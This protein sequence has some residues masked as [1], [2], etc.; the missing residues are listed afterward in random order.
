[1]QSIQ[2]KPLFLINCNTICGEG[3]AYLGL[4]FF[5]TQ[6]FP[7][8]FRGLSV[9]CVCHRNSTYSQTLSDVLNWWT[10]GK[11][12]SVH[13]FLPA[14]YHFTQQTQ[15]NVLN[16]SQIFPLFNQ[17]IRVHAC[18]CFKITENV[19]FVRFNK[20]SLRLGTRNK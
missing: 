15:Q 10:R 20:S 12:H 17:T 16:W 5:L 2:K 14:F 1:M 7:K 4:V 19:E 11:K 18:S 8:H 3:A 13:I 6:N 9:M